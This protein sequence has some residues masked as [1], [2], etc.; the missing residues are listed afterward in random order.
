[1]TT[2][3]NKGREL[4]AVCVDRTTGKVVH[5]AKLFEVGEP[6]TINK[7]NSY[8][9]PTPVIEAGRVY[10]HFGTYGTACL[11]TKTAKMIWTRRDLKCDHHM[12][13]G[14]SPIPY[15]K[16]LIIPVDGMD[17]Q[18][19]AALDRTTGKTVWKTERSVSYKGVSKYC[20]KAFCTP[21]VVKAAGR[22][23][24]ISPCARGIIAYD[25]DTGKELW[26]VQTKGFSVVPRPVSDGRRIYAVN[27]CDYPEMW[28][29]EANGKGNV[30]GS[31]I[32]WKLKKN[33]PQRAS[34]LLLD[35]LIYSVSHKGHVVC[36]D[37]KTGKPVWQERVGR[38]YSASPLYAEGRIYLFSERRGTTVIEPGRKYKAIATS[39]LDGRVM[40]SAAVA[41]KAFFIRTDSHLYRIEK[42]KASK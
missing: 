12:G 38:A 41:G 28:A 42:K 18:Y 13:P 35:G 6:D 9:S 33:M 26:K 21:S 36:I 15:G 2:A 24:L 3:D 25:P 7:M 29:I 17:V 4:F 39:I 23:Q 22:K 1:M 10:V 34:V 37:T 14:A 5:D 16:W 19:L 20:R 30:T 32:A 27:D 8:A 31:H 11:D 40:A